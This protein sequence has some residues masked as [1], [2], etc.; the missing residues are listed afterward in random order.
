MSSR[1]LVSLDFDGVI[2]SEAGY[3]PKFKH[4]DSYGIELAH[5][6]GYAVAVSTC[7][8]VPRVAEALR[9]K[10]FKV[11]ADLRMRHMFWDGG[12]DG[13]VVLV[14]G[15]KVA[16]SVYLDDKAIHFQYGDSWPQALDQM[17]QMISDRHG[18]VV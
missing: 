15:R 6:R 14:T 2:H 3:T 10:G 1:R 9:A 11:F 18:V 13:K 17:E 5:A 12:A 8:D 4:I 16:A 7:N